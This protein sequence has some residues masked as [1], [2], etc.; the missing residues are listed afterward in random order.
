MFDSAFRKFDSTIPKIDSRLLN[1]VSELPTLDS[2]MSTIVSE[3]PI[4]DSCANG[5]DAWFQ[6]EGHAKALHLSGQVCRGNGTKWS[7]QKRCTLLPMSS[8]LDY[9]D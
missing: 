2:G 4:A 8:D 3:G 1:G 9:F 7:G 5:G 6:V